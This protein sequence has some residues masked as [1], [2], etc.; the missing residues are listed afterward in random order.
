M[1]VIALTS[2]ER[3]EDIREAYR[4]HVNA[5]LVKP[6]TFAKLVKL[7]K[8]LKAFWLESVCPPLPDPA[9]E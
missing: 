5:Y 2:S 6:P 7:V 1:A 8:N 4:L 9:K 3:A